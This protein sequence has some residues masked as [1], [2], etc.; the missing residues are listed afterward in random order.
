MTLLI[1][2][3][4]AAHDVLAGVAVVAV[5]SELAATYFGQARGGERRF[6]GS[7]V[8]AMFLR[9]RGGAAAADR[10]TKQ[11]LVGS[12][13]VGFVAAYAVAAREP[14][15]RAY[16]NNWNTLV[17][18][19]VLALLGVALRSW[20]VWTLGRFFRR[21][22]TVEAGQ[23]VVSSGPDRWVRHPAYTGNLLTFAGFGL[24]LGSWVGAAILLAASI[25][26]HL[27]RIQVEEAELERSFGDEY[28]DYECTRARLIPGVW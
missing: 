13:L 21:E 23:R 4:R 17:A 19:A 24:A 26:G 6:V 14:A 15:L 20:A 16:A 18:G 8:E 2:H 9:K 25:A 5:A 10:W 7:V 3:D 27:P 1:Q 22:V 11:I 28:R 12:V